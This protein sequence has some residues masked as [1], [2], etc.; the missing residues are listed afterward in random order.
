M[1]RLRILLAL[2]LGTVAANADFM[3]T[4]EQTG[5]SNN[6]SFIVPTVI[7]AGADPLAPAI[8]Q[9]VGG[10]TITDAVLVPWDA[11]VFCVSFG[12]GNTDAFNCGLSDFSDLIG[13][14]ALLPNP[15]SVGVYSFFGSS[16]GGFPSLN[17]LTISEVPT[18][19][20]EPTSLI[21]L[22][23]LTVGLGWKLRRKLA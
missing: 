4:F 5:T 8:G 3:Y 2:L 10:F 14:Y 16:F 20:P 22:G 15:T 17:Q 12:A 18:A 9:I 6:F 21:L 11:T 19:V 13:E 1:P 23:T 7:T